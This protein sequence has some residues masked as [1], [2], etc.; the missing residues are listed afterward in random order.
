M[1]FD[2]QPYFCYTQAHKKQV[3][4]L[5]QKLSLYRDRIGKKPLYY[6]AKNSAIVFG[7]E[8]KSVLKHPECSGNLDFDALY[9][10]FALKNTSAP[11]TAYSDIKQLLPGHVLVWRKGKIE[12]RPYWKLDLS[13]P[14]HDISEQEAAEHLLELLDSAVKIR[15]RCDVPYGAFLSGGV[16]SSSVVML[17]NKAKSGSVKTF[18]LGYEDAAVGQFV[19]KND[20]IK[21]ARDV[22]KSL[23]TEYHEYIINAGKFAEGMPDVISSFDEPFSGTVSTFFLSTLIKKHVK[24]ALSGDGAD[25]LFGS[26]LAHRLAYPIENYFK[27]AKNNKSSWSDLNNN[28]KDLV[29]PFDTPEQFDFLKHVA[30][31]NIAQWRENLSVFNASERQE[32]LSADFLNEVGPVKTGRIYKEL[33]SGLTASDILNQ[34]LEID[35]KELLPNQVLPFVDRLSMAHSVEV[36][37]PYLDYRIIEFANKLPGSLKI[38]NGINKYIHKKAME[39]ILPDYIL[40]RPKEGFVQPIYSWMHTRLKGWVLEQMDLLPK[41][42]FNKKYVDKLAERFKGDDR[43]LNAKVWNLVCYSLWHQNKLS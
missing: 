33:K 9:D 8:I 43:S 7:S 1:F 40:Q 31:E 42:F 24:V 14:L 6:M 28:D 29:R 23:N 25:E 26:Y 12:T 30:S 18:S 39:K 35:Q 27:L 4:I 3:L 32:L 41:E 34:S 17:M 11:K 13:S 20:D 19:G 15:M 22:S 36:R 2:I 5:Q 37:S 10:Y 16:D 21:F 38:R